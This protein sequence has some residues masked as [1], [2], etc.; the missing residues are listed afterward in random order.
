M[1]RFPK[2]LPKFASIAPCAQVMHR[3]IHCKGKMFCIFS[4]SNTWMFE[5]LT[6]NHAYRTLDNQRST[7][8][9][10]VTWTWFVLQC[11]CKLQG[12]SGISCTLVLAQSCL[13]VHLSCLP[14]IVLMLDVFTHL[15]MYILSCVE[16]IFIRIVSHCIWI[17]L[18]IY[19]YIYTHKSINQPTASFSVCVTA[20]LVRCHAMSFSESGCLMLDRHL[21][22]FVSCTQFSQIT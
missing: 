14:V 10:H 5:P 17:I 20:T 4:I 6:A 18:N 7:S 11:Y 9:Q 1:S 15:S 8:C 16:N 21:L 19:I 22:A 3:K 12:H 2:F 13:T